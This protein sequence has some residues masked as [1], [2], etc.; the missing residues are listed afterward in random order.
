[1]NF[2]LFGSLKVQLVENREF[3][4]FLSVCLKNHKTLAIFF[5]LVIGF[6]SVQTAVASVFITQAVPA[7]VHQIAESDNASNNDCHQVIKTQTVCIHDNPCSS[8]GC[9][10][11]HCNACFTVILDQL[12]ASLNLAKPA[13]NLFFDSSHYATHSV[14]LFRPPII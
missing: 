5:A 8:D 12:S 9:P 11:G 10:D 2:K 13:Y 14:A 6:A 1:M 7:E 3:C 4:Y